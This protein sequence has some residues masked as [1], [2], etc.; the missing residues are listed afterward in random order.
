[1]ICNPS[2]YGGIQRGRGHRGRPARLSSVR[3]V[4]VGYRFVGWLHIQCVSRGKKATH[5]NN[6]RGENTTFPWQAGKVQM[7]RLIITFLYDLTRRSSSSPRPAS[8]ITSPPKQES[9]R[10]MLGSVEP[11]PPSLPFAPAPS[12]CAV[13]AAIAEIIRGHNATAKRLMNGF[14][15]SSY[16]W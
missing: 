7:A 2:R 8:P 6:S 12:S 5:R 13:V 1:M 15:K 3:I 11:V 4:A 10:V 9:A 16:L 14:L